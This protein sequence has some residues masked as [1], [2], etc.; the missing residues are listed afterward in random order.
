MTWT[1]KKEA[2][3]MEVKPNETKPKNTAEGEFRALFEVPGKNEEK[4]S[5]YI[6]E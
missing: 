6:H 1:K 3:K 4:K 5:V 2:E